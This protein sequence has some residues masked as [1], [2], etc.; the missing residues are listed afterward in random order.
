MRRLPVRRV[1]GWKTIRHTQH[2]ECW[3]LSNFGEDKVL[4][5]VRRWRLDEN[6]VKSKFIVLMTREMWDLLISVHAKMKWE[7]DSHS[8]TCHVLSMLNYQQ[9]ILGYVVET[10]HINFRMRY[11]RY[12]F[13]ADLTT[14]RGFHVLMT[15][16]PPAKPPATRQLLTLK[17]FKNHPKCENH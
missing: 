7:K 12:V 14:R 9:N 11:K 5:A 2:D 16:F 17:F 13:S 15:Q 8:H 1:K 10:T 4:I 6:R 3:G